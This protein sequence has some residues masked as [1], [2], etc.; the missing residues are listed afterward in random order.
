MKIFSRPVVDIR[1]RAG[2]TRLYETYAGFVFNICFDYLNDEILSENL[3]ADI[4]A[5]LW[6]RRDFLHQ[7]S[8]AKKIEWKNY[9]SSA[10]KNKIFDHIRTTE[11]AKKYRLFIQNDFPFYQYTTDEQ[12]D[13]D[14]S[15]SHFRILAEFV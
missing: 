6:E 3:T 2:Y 5:S 10:A 14:N 1:T 15:N 9:L 8:L 7:S 4:F 12:I 13:Y 11:Q